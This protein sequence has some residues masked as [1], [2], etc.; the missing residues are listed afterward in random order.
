M[1]CHFAAKMRGSKRQ[2]VLFVTWA[3]QTYPP[4]LRSGC[5]K[6]SGGKVLFVL[7]RRKQKF[8]VENSIQRLHEKVPHFPDLERKRFFSPESTQCPQMSQS[9]SISISEFTVGCF[10]MWKNKKSP[11]WLEQKLSFLGPGPLTSANA[12]VRELPGPR[13]DNRFSLLLRK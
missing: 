7:P 4:S 11:S 8:F 6:S 2:K 1:C 13:K 12:S 3:W 5:K 10:R 9:I